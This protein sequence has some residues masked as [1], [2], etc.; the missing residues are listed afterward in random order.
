[1]LQG[2]A[3]NPSASNAAPKGTIIPAMVKPKMDFTIH[4]I[5][6]LK[7]VELELLWVGESH[8]RPATA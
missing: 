2:D 5:F 4:Q 6:F 1:M 3:N 8:N 7:G